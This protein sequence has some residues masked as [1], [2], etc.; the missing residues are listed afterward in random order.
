MKP[1]V[2]LSKPSFVSLIVMAF[3]L[4][5]MG[6]ACTQKSEAPK[7]GKPLGEEKTVVQEKTA[8]ETSA[9]TNEFKTLSATDRE[10][11]LKVQIQVPTDWFT[12]KDLNDD[13]VI[14][15][16]NKASNL[17]AVVISEPKDQF[18]KGTQ[19]KDYADIVIENFLEKNEEQAKAKKEAVKTT[20]N[21][22]PALQYEIEMKLS[23]IT[24]ITMLYTIVEGSKGFHQIMAWTYSS[25][26]D[27]QQPLLKTITDS[28]REE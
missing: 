1:S 16:S 22:R 21:G 19:L 11:H 13:A 28:F 8:T 27:E 23:K 2:P 9:A 3:F 5:L 10:N 26:W 12:R 7:K 20:V 6:S 18:D 17:F 4:A 24:S 15:A 14:Q 25:R